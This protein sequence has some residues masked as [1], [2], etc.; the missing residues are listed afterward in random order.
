[1]ARTVYALL[2]AIDDF[3]EPIPPLSGCVADL[4]AMVARK[5][6]A[7]CSTAGRVRFDESRP[8]G[9]RWRKNPD[10]TSRWIGPFRCGL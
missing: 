3:P 9:D 8:G 5:R 4:E 2:V 1:M 7:S 6:A 10:V